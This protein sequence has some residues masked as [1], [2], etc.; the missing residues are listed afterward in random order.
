MDV[1][2]IVIDTHPPTTADSIILCAKGSSRR[3]G[4][5]WNGSF[6]FC[7]RKYNTKTRCERVKIRLTIK[8]IP[9]S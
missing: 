7:S 2:K 3:I 9:S 6:S 5:K 8:F 1:I 4:V